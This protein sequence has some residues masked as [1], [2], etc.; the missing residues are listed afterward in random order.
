MIRIRNSLTGED[1][2]FGHASVARPKLIENGKP[3]SRWQP[4][5]YVQSFVPEALTAINNAPAISITTTPVNSIDFQKYVATL[6][7]SRFQTP[8]PI[9]PMPQV[10][11]SQQQASQK[12]ASVQQILQ[13]RVDIPEYG[14]YFQNCLALDDK[15]H[16]RELRNF[17]MFGAKVTILDRAKTTFTVKVPGLRE[18]SPS[19]KYGDYIML[20]QW[21]EQPALSLNLGIYGWKPTSNSRPGFTGYES[22]A[23]VVAVDKITDTLHIRAFGLLDTPQIRC[24]I[25][26]DRQPHLTQRLQVAVF[27]VAKELRKTS[28]GQSQLSPGPIQQSKWLK[29]MLF[30]TQECG[31]VQDGLPSA[32]FALQWVDLALNY[33]Q[34]KAVNSVATS[35]YGELCYLINGPAGTGKTKTICEMVIQ[36]GK[37]YDLEGCILLCAPSNQ[38]ADTLALRLRKLF[39]PTEMLRLNHFSRTFAEL[40][41]DIMLYCFIEDSIFSL[42]PVD[43]LMRYKIVITTCHDADSLIQARLSNRD[44]FN[45]HRDM[46]RVLFPHQLSRPPCPPLHWSAL[47]IDEAAQATEP[48]ILIPLSVVTPPTDA[49]VEVVQPLFVMAGDQHQLGPR[50]YDTTTRLHVSLFERLSNEPVYAEHPLARKRMRNH[51]AEKHML[52]PPFANLTRNYRSHPALLAVPSS[53]FYSNTLIPEVTNIHIAAEWHKWSHRKPG[54]PVHF[55]INGGSDECED[56]Q[57]STHGWYNKAEASKAIGC[58]QDIL[59]TLQISDQSEICI[60]SPFRAQVRYLRKVAR[61][62]GLH[63]LNIGPLEAFQGLEKRVVIICTTRARLRF[64]AD[65]RSRGAGVIWEPKKF[66]VALTRAKEGLVVIGNPWVLASDPFWLAFLNYC[67]RNDLYWKDPVLDGSTLMQNTQEGKVNDWTPEQKSEE[68]SGVD[69]GGL[70]SALLFKERLQLEGPITKR[71]LLGH[72]EDE[73]WRSGVEAEETV[74]A[75]ADLTVDPDDE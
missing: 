45:L 13:Q 53:L 10:D 23:I 8:L 34:K 12:E 62:R 74:G 73:Q 70:E 20:R 5:V 14:H 57:S 66:N 71:G 67:W 48:E 69:N 65:D 33:E 55:V 18:E 3:T 38:A 40:P 19:V 22:T 32:N 27:D 28:F 61:E 9:V 64:L 51:P 41:M 42:P 36:L 26:F 35:N 21:V 30:P 31:V 68:G 29:N 47:I 15:G 75:F 72:L 63:T 37:K 52:R 60:M 16:E 2:K 50:T 24:N 17:D 4:D 6:Y 58:A 49:P 59:K 39:Q 25:I 54:W 46:S 43:R 7:G 1:V 11:L 56:I 44:L